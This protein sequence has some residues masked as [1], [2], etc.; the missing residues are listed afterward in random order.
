M[1]ERRVVL[2]TNVLVGSAY[3]PASASRQIV[4][5]CLRGELI[6]V[7]SPA[8]K[9]EYDHILPRAIRTGDPA[10]TLQRLLEQA[11]WV[12]PAQTPRVVPE[13]PQDDKLVAAGLAA[14]V[15]AIITNDRHLLALDPLG[16]IRIL[17]PAAFVR[18]QAETEG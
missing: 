1:P 13:D 10:E 11:A 3:A 12:E 9:Q 5:A 16:T 7:L 15:E 18:G 2:D 8:L 17:R 6:P 14:R 4:D